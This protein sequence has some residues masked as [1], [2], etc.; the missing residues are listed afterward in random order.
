MPS[1]QAV[2]RP[3]VPLC[4]G[5]VLSLLLAPQ[6]TLDTS[7]FPWI[8]GLTGAA[9][10]LVGRQ[11]M[12]LSPLLGFC[13]MVVLGAWISADGRMDQIQHA[14]TWLPTI[15]ETVELE[16]VGVVLAI[17]EPAG[18]GERHLLIDGRPEALSPVHSG[19]IRLRIRASPPLPT[20]GLD[21]LR[22]GDIVRVWCRIFR[23]RSLGNPGAKDASAAL[24]T[25]GLDAYG[26]VKSARLVTRSV[27][28]NSALA[29]TLDGLKAQSRGDLTRI[30]RGAPAVRSLLGALLLG[31]RAD[32]HP[33]LRRQLRDA[34]LLHLVAI[35][36]LHVGLLMM[37]TVWML[38]R[39]RCAPVLILLLA[40]C[41][42]VPF[43]MFVGARP[44]V[45]R[46]V[47]GCA[48][49]LFA[50]TIGRTGDPLNL[51][52]VLAG[53]LLLFEP[54]L[55]HS[56]AFQLTFMAT[57]GILRIS[58]RIQ[59]ALAL[60]APISAAIAISA[61]AYLT[62]APL[63]AWHFGRL[64]PVSMLSNLP[65]VPLLAF[66]LSGG[67]GAMLFRHLPA[68]SEFA[69][70]VATSASQGLLVVARQATDIEV[71]SFVVARPAGAI[72]VVYYLL[73][74]LTG[75]WTLI[76]QW[77]GALGA[78]RVRSV[79]R[80]VFAAVLLWLH[81]GPPPPTSS[82]PAFSLIDVGQGQAMLMHSPHGGLYLA[83]AGGSF[84]PRFDPGEQIV[85]P[86]IVDGGGR[87][88]EAIFIS[89]EHLDHAGGAFAVLRDLEVGA[90]W[91]G[92]GSHRSR[93][94][95]ELAALAREQGTAIV[96]A[97]RG[98]RVDDARLPID[99]LGPPRRSVC[100]TVHDRSVS[101]SVGSA[102]HRVLIPGDL[103]TCGE[104]ELLTSPVPL[105]SEV[106][107][108][109][110]HGSQEGTTDAFL[111]LVRP[112]HALISAGRGNPFGH[113]DADVIA[114]L[115]GQ[116]ITVWRTDRDGMV[117]LLL[118]GD[119]WRLSAFH[120][121]DRD[122]DEGEHKDHDQE[123]GNQLPDWPDR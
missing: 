119:R 76:R 20:A 33:E 85:V 31:D 86:L 91:L 89:H 74:V 45:L 109:S 51:L 99:I 64:A 105:G 2:S 4:L 79:A 56:P 80:S 43:V 57:A 44:S 1:T 98:G 81:L 77:S 25:S 104:Q 69:G 84:N 108:V 38:R 121:T 58:P 10:L 34:G 7:A 50:R 95:Q 88:L 103:E 73:L 113:P 41:F 70:W 82:T 6:Y 40:T 16:L 22:T 110:H 39:L 24:M 115:K 66:A 107:V 42:M 23:P 120:D 118:E 17:P 114:R 123:S 93:L 12:G 49:I 78:H 14:A 61:A 47:I 101:L 32:L 48:V 46:A 111:D 26:T 18:D 90:L 30:S 96:L 60:P 21:D 62:T 100:T 59:P 5:L 97:E 35:S 83:D 94:M 75:E 117:R 112:A 67:Y 55:V 102:P 71:G 87:R 54:A 72:G 11:V 53:V 52:A 68:V 37:S 63:V 92:V 29:R 13:A 116:D 106:L 36:G 28:G 9:W 8:A 15:G 3:A 122:L 65:C 19:R 27:Q